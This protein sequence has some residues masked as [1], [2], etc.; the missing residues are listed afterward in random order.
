M[1]TKR[2]LSVREVATILDVSV[3]EIRRRIHTGAIPAE[4]L[5]GRT[6]AWLIPAGAVTVT[7]QA[8]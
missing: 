6:G 7:E 3:S 2:A 5:P 8:A 4:K 1:T